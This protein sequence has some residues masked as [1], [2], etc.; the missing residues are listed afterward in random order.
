MIHWLHHLFNPHC[1]DCMVVAVENKVCNSCETLKVQLA[2]AN[3]EKRQLLNTILSSVTPTREPVTA[4]N[5]EKLAPKATTWNVRRQ[6]LEAEDRERAK[7]LSQQKKTV[8]EQIDELEK[9]VGLEQE[10]KNA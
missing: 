9:E 7:I 6:M 10:V 2:I 1:P 8:G 4:L 3:D 5:Y